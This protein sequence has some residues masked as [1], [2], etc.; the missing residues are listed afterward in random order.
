[1]ASVRGLRESVSG[2]ERRICSSK[3]GVSRSRS[4]SSTARRVSNTFPHAGFARQVEGLTIR[5]PRHLQG[6][7]RPLARIRSLSPGGSVSRD[8]APAAPVLQPSGRHQHVLERLEVLGLP[9]A[10]GEADGPAKRLAEGIQIPAA[11]TA[12]PGCRPR[13]TGRSTGKNHGGP[14]R[15]TR[16]PGVTTRLKFSGGDPRAGHHHLR[17]DGHR[18]W[19]G[20]GAALRGLARRT[21]GNPPGHSFS[22]GRPLQSAGCRGASRFRARGRRVPTRGSP[23]N[24]ASPAPPCRRRRSTAGPGAE[25]VLPQ[26]VVVGT[27]KGAFKHPLGRD[28]ADLLNAPARALACVVGA[29]GP[30]FAT[31]AACASS[32]VAVGRGAWLSSRTESATRC[33]WEGPRR[34]TLCRLPGI[35][36]AASTLPTTGDALRRRAQWVVP[37]RGS[38]SP[39]PGVAG[40]CRGPRRRPLAVVE[41]FGA[42]TDGYDQIAPEPGG[43]GLS[44]ASRRALGRCR[45]VGRGGGRLSRTRNGHRAERSDGSRSLRHA[46]RRSRGHGVGNQGLGGPYARRRRCARRGRLRMDVPSAARPTGHQLEQDRPADADPGGDGSAL[47][48]DG[49]AVPRGQRRF[50]RH[51]RQPPV[52][53]RSATARCMRSGVAV[54]SWPCL[55]PASA[56]LVGLAPEPAAPSRRPG[57]VRPVPA[58]TTTLVQLARG[59]LTLSSIASCPS[60]SRGHRHPVG[61]PHRV[62]AERPGLSPEHGGSGRRPRVRPRSSPSRSPPPWW[63]RWQCLSDFAARW[64]PSAA[65]RSAAWRR[66]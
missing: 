5:H 57:R 36:H 35:P 46:L 50:W 37:R 16:W 7:S 26:G 38:C 65:R 1:M 34:C 47:P 43:R 53:L 66:W 12:E 20:C 56:P 28:Q 15:L 14:A 30:C 63:E 55:D 52:V 64:P 6:G 62:R 33:W 49:R 58:M 2:R 59:V 18:T 42:A 60:A 8:Q 22:G 24:R 41:G 40:R 45:R 23:R 3:S 32:V 19:S 29:R 9:E 13:S 51:H 27:T 39:G 17:R 21:I 48:A 31:S 44:A 54:T 4:A 11:G 61:D 10:G 25:P